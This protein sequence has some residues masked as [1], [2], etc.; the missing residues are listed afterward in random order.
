MKIAESVQIPQATP[1]RDVNVFLNLVLTNMQAA[2]GEQFIGFYL[3]GSLALGD[4]DPLRSDIDFVAVT[5]DELLP[6]M[7][8]ALE[9]M[10]TRLWAT[11][12]KWA[13]KLAGSY[14][15]RQVLRCWISEHTPCPFV[16]E[17]RFCVTNQGSAVIQRHIIRQYGV[18]VAGPSPHTLIDPVDAEDLRSAL[19]DMLEKWWR[20]LL[21]DPAWLQQSQKQP[22]AILTMCRALYT[23]EHGVVAS[24]PVAA[25]WGQQAIGEQWQTLI[26]WALAWPHVTKSNHL[27]STLG[28][29]QYTLNRYTHHDDLV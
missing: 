17:D 19:R 11:G 2:L 4:F 25:R 29:I 8:I 15:P 9:E 12:T 22:F 28:L 14:V 7:L 23:L 6:E 10:H 16:E 24:K 5:A 21:D 26:E 18:V 1:Y 13:M 20:P 3:G 27:A